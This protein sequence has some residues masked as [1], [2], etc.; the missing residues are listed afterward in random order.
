MAALAKTQ[1]EEAQGHGLPDRDA[2]T[3]AH[4]R[5][6][7]GRPQ[8]GDTGGLCRADSARASLQRTRQLDIVRD[9]G[10]RV[11]ASATTALI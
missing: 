8:A 4:G 3:P 2:A 11:A 7:G 5:H 10:G 9:A 1:R 6:D